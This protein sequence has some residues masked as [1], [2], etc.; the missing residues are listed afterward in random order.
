MK[1]IR[2]AAIICAIALI[3]VHVY[4]KPK[5]KVYEPFVEDKKYTH[6]WLILSTNEYRFDA[7]WNPDDKLS[8]YRILRR[9]NAWLRNY[10]NARIDTYSIT[11]IEDDGSGWHTRG[12]IDSMQIFNYNFA[13]AIICFPCK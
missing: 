5:N 7:A 11:E 2:N 1:K 3:A 10:H 8:E 6:K 9:A 12:S 4:F 13:T